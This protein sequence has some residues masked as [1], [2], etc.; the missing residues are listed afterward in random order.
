MPDPQSIAACSTDPQTQTL[1]S[2]PLPLH[3][4]SQIPSQTPTITRNSK[5]YS[6][7]PQTLRIHCHSPPILR[8]YWGR[9]WTR[10]PLAQGMPGGLGFGDPGFGVLQ[11]YIEV[12][13]IGVRPSQRT[14]AISASAGQYGAAPRLARQST[15]SPRKYWPLVSRST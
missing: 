10:R 4:N 13:G 9:A 15:R 14:I 5:P 12:L 2:G 11:C 3:P 6:L 8:G 7:K 1:K